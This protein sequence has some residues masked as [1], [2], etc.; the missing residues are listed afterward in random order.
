MAVSAVVLCLS[1]TK[2][3][4]AVST[5][6]A[7]GADVPLMGVYATVVLVKVA[8]APAEAARRSPQAL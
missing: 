6:I 8:G 7:C 3:L 4:P 1:A 2:R 5:A